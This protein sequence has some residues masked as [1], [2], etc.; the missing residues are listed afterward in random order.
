MIVAKRHIHMTKKDAEEFGVT[1]GQIVSV[2]ID[3]K[4]AR[5]AILS[6]VVIRVSD[7]YALAMH[8]DTDE[9]NALG[10]DSSFTG[11]I[12]K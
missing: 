2:K 3:S 7:S 5:S 1:N 8:I 10:G 11:T 4:N 6:D 12:V 9:A